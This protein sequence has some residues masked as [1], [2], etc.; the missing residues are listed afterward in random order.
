MTWI[1]NFNTIAFLAVVFNLALTVYKSL[2]ISDELLNRSKHKSLL[3]IFLDF[4]PCLEDLLC[5]VS[6]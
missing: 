2:S 3:S 6:D 5:F 4:C 1:I